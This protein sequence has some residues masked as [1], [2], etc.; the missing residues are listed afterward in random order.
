MKVIKKLILQVHGTTLLNHEEKR[1]GTVIVLD[2]VTHLRKLENI[3]KDFVANVSHELRTPIT[4]IQGFVET[5]MEGTIDNKEEALRFLSIIAKHTERLSSIIDDLLSLSRIEQGAEENGISKEVCNI[6]D[7][8]LNAVQSC[9]LK[10]DA[11]NIKLDLK[12]NDDLLLRINAPL[13]EQAVTNLIDNA[14]KY[15][16]RDSVIY[17]KALRNNGDVI[18]SVRDQGVG[19]KTEH[20]ERIFERFYRIDKARSRKLGGTG[21]GLA[22]VKHISQVHGGYTTVESSFGKGSTFHIHLPKKYL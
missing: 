1:I 17:I 2:N 9:I 18:I 7:V 5:L 4:S 12:C 19:I 21:L 10:A 22:I 15:S 14:I 13:I 16:G 8:L 6:K 20:L 11:G 3:R